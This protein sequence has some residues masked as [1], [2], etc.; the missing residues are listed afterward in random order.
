MRTGC[1]AAAVALASLLARNART[2]EA[3]DRAQRIHA[4]LVGIEVAAPAGETDRAHRRLAP[5]TDRAARVLAVQ[6]KY[7]L[8]LS[9]ELHAETASH[10]APTFTH[11]FYRQRFDQPTAELIYEL[12][13][14]SV[15]YHAAVRDDGSL[16]LEANRK[17]HF[18]PAAAAAVVKQDLGQLQCL[19]IY[20]DGLLAADWS[21]PDRYKFPPVYFV[22]FAGER[23]RWDDRTL[24]VQEFVKP[25]AG[26]EALGH[27]GEP[28]R[29]GDVL[30]W[31]TQSMLHTFDLKSRERKSV[32]LLTQLHASQRVTAFDGAT[33]VCGVYA[34][35]AATGALLGE[36]EYPRRPTN[37][38]SVFAVRNRIGYYYDSGELKATDLTA[39]DGASV[40]V[41]DAQPVAALEGKEGLTV[42]DGR[43]WTRVPWLKSLA[44]T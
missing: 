40:R 35:D 15:R 19:D 4:D 13:D 6:P 16:L 42:W 30:A 28:Y 24:V 44:Q 12:E 3:A 36:P 27:R 10:R 37:V 39:R 31:V 33:V 29:H 11:R 1:L 26:N 14:T 20:P 9:S 17:F 41:R 23:L 2:D 25:F 32:Q 5:S 8:W 21:G 34:F 38:A 18:V 7:A 43:T 22:P